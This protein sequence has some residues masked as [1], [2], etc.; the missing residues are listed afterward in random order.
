ME[1]AQALLENFLAHVQIL[2]H[3]RQD[4]VEKCAGTIQCSVLLTVIR[5]HGCPIGDAVDTTESATLLVS[6]QY[7][8]MARGATVAKARRR[9]IV[10]AQLECRGS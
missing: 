4:P 9:Y 2:G 6:R 3:Q 8:A 5:A 1:L 7:S 10:Q